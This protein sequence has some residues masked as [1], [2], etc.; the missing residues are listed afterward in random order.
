MSDHPDP[1]DL[2]DQIIAQVEALRDA[3]ERERPDPRH[4][5]VREGKRHIGFFV[6]V[7][8]YKAVR[9][10]GV[11]E[12]K[13]LQRLMLE[14]VDLLLQSRGKPPVAVKNAPPEDAE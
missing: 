9:L 10:V 8:T 14:A 13:R 7:E 5:G 11:D 2:A 3:V 6:D 4:P 12:H 1:H